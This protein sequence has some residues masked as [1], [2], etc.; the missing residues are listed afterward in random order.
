VGAAASEPSVTVSGDER[1]TNGDVS[2]SMLEL[3]TDVYPWPDEGLHVLA[4]IGPAAVGYNHEGNESDR[5]HTTMEG[6]VYTLGVGWEG[7]VG[8]DW[9]IGG[10]LSLNWASLEDDDVDFQAPSASG[11]VF[12]TV[13]AGKATGSLFMPTLSFAATFH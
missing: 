13:Y 12:E 5:S 9:S 10:M 2:V 3:F 7:W 11:D 8:K 4:G 6:V 1:S